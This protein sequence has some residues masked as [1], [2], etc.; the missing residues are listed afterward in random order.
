MRRWFT[1]ICPCVSSKSAQPSLCGA[2]HLVPRPTFEQR[3]EI[4]KQLAQTVET[5][6]S[7]VRKA[8]TDGLN[9]LGGK[10]EPGADD[11]D[12]IHTEFKVQLEETLAAA[13][14]AFEKV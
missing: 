1:E 3:A 4:L 12:K 10:G 13:K 7:Q 9:T 11:V 6:K 2:D 5:A 14:R 8:R